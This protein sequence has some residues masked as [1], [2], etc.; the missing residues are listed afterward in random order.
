[1][2]QTNDANAF[3]NQDST[4]ENA[5]EVWEEQLQ[6]LVD[7]YLARLRAG[8]EPDTYELML[9]HLPIALEVEERLEMA[10]QLFRLA[11][12]QRQAEETSRGGESI[13]EGNRM[14][15][16]GTPKTSP[17]GEERTSPPI[18]RYELQEIL[19][20]GASGV[21]YQAFDP[22]LCRRVALKVLRPDRPASAEAVR[23]FERDARI[24]ASLH[25]PNI[26]PVYETGEERGQR[27]FVM[28]LIAGETLEARLQ[29]GSMPLRP[30]TELVS[31]L[32]SALAYAH[33][34]GVVHRDVKPANI[35]LAKGPGRAEEPF[36][37]DFGL[38]RHAGVEESITQ[39]GDLLGTP[40]YMTPEQAQGRADEAD[41]RSDVYSLGAVFFHMLA[42]RAPF[43]AGTPA[44]L[45]AKIV[46]EPPPR[47]RRINAAVPPDLETICLKALAKEPARRF[48]TAQDFADE[49]GRWLRQEPL[50]TRPPRLWEVLWLWARR[51]R[52]TAWVIGVSAVLLALVSAVL[53]NFAWA[54][55]DEAQ[56]EKTNAAVEQ[57]KAVT[58]AETRAEVEVMALHAQAA[59]RLQE[60]TEGRRRDAQAIL[61]KVAEPRRKIVPGA[62]T[63]RLDLETRSLFAAT[64]GVPDL[65]IVAVEQLPYSPFAVWPAAIHPDGKSIVIGY[66]RP[67]RAWRWTEGKPLNLPKD[68]GTIE[69]RHPVRFS[70]DG[71]LLL[72]LPTGGGLEVWDEDVTRNTD[73]DPGGQARYLAVGFERAGKTLCGCRADG[74]VRCWSLPDLKPLAPWKGGGKKGE[75]LSAAAFNADANLLLVG[76]G[77]GASRICWPDGQSQPLPTT[78]GGITAV[79]LSPDS[80]L[81]AVGNED[82]IAQLWHRSGAAPVPLHRLTVGHL[83]VRS[84]VFHPDGAYLFASG[85]D[86][87]RGFDIGTGRQVLTGPYGAWAFAKDGWRFAGASRG[88]VAFCELSPPET[89]LPLSGNAGAIGH[90]AWS[91]DNQTL[92]SIDSSYVARV[93]NAKKGILLNEFTPPR[94]GYYAASA[95]IALSDDGGQLAYVSGGAT[96]QV[97]L[98][99]VKEGKK[100]GE[101]SLG[102]GFE[103]LV[104]AG[105][106]RFLLVREEEKEE[107]KNSFRSAAFEFAADTPPHEVCQVRAAEAD[108]RG[109]FDSGLTP[110][111]RYYWWTGPRTPEKAY[112]VEVREVATGRLVT[113]AQE[114]RAAARVRLAQSFVRDGLTREAIELYQQ[115]LAQYPLT[116]GAARARVV[117]GQMAPP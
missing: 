47:L 78:R 57:A 63:T 88:Q 35:V 75:R 103:R 85:R 7:D 32:A 11:A 45:F 98:W 16:F 93:W 100:L 39:R 74:E 50:K 83:E 106:V 14:S 21:V 69:D 27:Y 91:R 81:A 72:L 108:E 97:L 92:A 60:P 95:T 42:G 64:L 104:C 101:W 51:N 110:D 38:A 113:R 23:A 10:A 94:G 15:P 76:D 115:V 59:R 36:L 96:S 68:V 30:A 117:L 82:G 66:G 41:A 34:A 90:T 77:T 89:P 25:H 80:R 70:P 102:L 109:F 86:G 67:P 9:L 28:E 49:L 22:V 62:A 73:L 52:A 17:V 71:K 79:A 58:A 33:S 26:V 5:A 44:E 8:E 99:D 1:M 105:G 31:K 24:A 19:G 116:E 46:T 84:I 61:Q 37:T 40:K 18:G 87:L 65:Q 3:P 53:G 12:A 48:A 111:G 114:D 29:Q 55:H 107:G 20:A 56:R 2:S 13:A 4:L 112:R 6:A 43:E 54:K